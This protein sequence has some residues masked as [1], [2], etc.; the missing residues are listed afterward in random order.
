[1]QKCASSWNRAEVLRLW[2]QI[3]ES[4]P[5]D[6]PTGKQFEYLVIRAFELEGIDVRWPYTVLLKGVPGVVEQIDG[7]IYLHKQAFIVE[8]KNLSEPAAIE[9]LAR[10]RFRLERRPPG[11]MAVL[12]GF[13][14]FTVATEV[15]AQYASPMNVLLWNRNDMDYALTRGQ[16][17]QGL[18]DKMQYAIEFGNPSLRL[19]DH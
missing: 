2:A 4:M 1:M 6:W 7:A 13:S 10:L 3:K 19:E 12:F 14:D 11:T 15:F 18:E 17:A 5:S 8:S 9:A 16:M